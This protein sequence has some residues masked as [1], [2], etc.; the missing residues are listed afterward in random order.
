MKRVGCYNDFGYLNGKRPFTKTKSFRN[1]IQWS[2]YM[3]SLQEIAMKCGAFAREHNHR[4]RLT[5][6]YQV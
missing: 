3:K 1:E 2:I 6:C 4:V 5:F